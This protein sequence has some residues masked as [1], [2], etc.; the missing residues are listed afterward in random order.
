[1]TCS[2]SVSVIGREGAV[3]FRGRP[4]RGTSRAGADGD[5]AKTI[6]KR[7]IASLY[8]FNAIMSRRVPLVL[9][10]ILLTTC[11]GGTTPPTP[12][13]VADP[14]AITCPADITV[15]GIPGPS[16]VVTYTV[17]T[18]IGGAQ[19]VTTS[20]T[21]A[22]G[23]VFPLGTTA[24]SCAAN[25]AQS[26][27]GTCGF[28]VTLTG[29]G[30]GAK[31]FE[32]FGDSLTEGENGV[33]SKPAV[34]DA[35]NSYPTK[36][37][38]LFD[39]EFPGQGIVVI[40]R[41]E[42]GKKVEETLGRLPEFLIADRPEAVLLLTGYNNLTTPCFP[43]LADTPACETAVDVVV[44]GVRDCIRRAKESSVGV[45]YVFVSTLTP[46]GPVL[47]TAPKNLRIAIETI[48][49]VN[50]RI[51]QTVAAE[52]ATLVDTY[53]LF[54]GREAEYVSG[55]GLHLRPAGY[56]AIA[57]AFFTAIKATVPQ[58]PLSTVNGLR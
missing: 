9:A 47:P 20:C 49:E 17:P 22:S 4:L 30:L 27:R 16:Q 40:N 37:R 7:L 21:P 12:V 6:S 43:G 38:A 2:G 44:D 24:V 14:P 58:A 54:V 10:A 45:K 56:Q 1:M 25:D 28:N 41:G 18:A 57:N 46:S 52:K 42:G 34:V 31:K 15:R 3:N 13:P 23:G 33:N 5:R 26:R 29:I 35:A 8:N 11:G 39:A 55:D 32:T 50:R 36:L 48:I 51:R 53:Q 19:P